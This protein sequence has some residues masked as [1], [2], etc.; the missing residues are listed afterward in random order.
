MELIYSDPYYD[1]EVWEEGRFY[2][3]LIHN[4]LEFDADVQGYEINIGHG[5][6]WP[7]VLIK[8]FNEVNW[9]SFLIASGVGVFFLGDKINKNLEAWLC[10]REKIQKVIVKLRPSRIDENFAALMAI[11]DFIK[12]G[13]NSSELSLTL[14]IIE[15]SPLSGSNEGKL[16][17][18]PD[19]LYLITIKTAGK[20]LVYG[21]KSNGKLEFKYYFETNW[22]DFNS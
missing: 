11:N 22:H 14:Q 19:A 13:G 2:R 15:F 21:I 20:A 5:A 6:D 18:R 8:I 16:C 12:N 4:L 10:I 7:A 17:Y 3:E 9:D 1:Q